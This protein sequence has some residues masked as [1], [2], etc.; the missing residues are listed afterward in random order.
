MLRKEAAYCELTGA[1]GIVRGRPRWIGLG[2]VDIEA[3][4]LVRCS[5]CEMPAAVGGLEQR[6]HQARHGIRL[7]GFRLELSVGD[8]ADMSIVEANGPRTWA[9]TGS[10]GFR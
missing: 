9:I 4:L 6:L 2:W 10:A 3:S 8:N 1:S 5:R 7:G